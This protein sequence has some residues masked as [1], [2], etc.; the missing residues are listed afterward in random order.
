MSSH[1]RRRRRAV[2]GKQLLAL[3]AA[4]VA[5]AGGEACAKAPRAKEDGVGRAAV[6]LVVGASSPPVA[7]FPALE[8][9]E[10]LADVV[11][12]EG[13]DLG[14][15]LVDHNQERPLAREPCSAAN[16]GERGRRVLARRRLVKS[17]D[18]RLREQ[19][20]RKTKPPTSRSSSRM[21]RLIL[22]PHYLYP[23]VGE[24]RR[25]D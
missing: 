16:Q 10:G 2:N 23:R 13:E 22:I 14:G 25:V 5:E 24:S 17:K 6:V 20:D 11:V 21:R 1:G 19:V 7:D 9:D 8:L 3:G 15:R 12:E 18:R 4:A